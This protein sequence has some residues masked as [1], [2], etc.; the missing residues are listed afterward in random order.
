MATHSSWCTNSTIFSSQ[1]FPHISRTNGNGNFQIS[2]GEVCSHD[3]RTQNIRWALSHRVNILLSH[4]GEKKVNTTQ[5]RHFQKKTTFLAYYLRLVNGYACTCISPHQ[6]FKCT[7]SK[8][9][10]QRQR[11]AMRN[12]LLWPHHLRK[13]LMPNKRHLC[14]KLL[15]S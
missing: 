6:K 2:P 13:V 9:R 8:S 15:S 10:Q 7:E 11:K 3:W 5:Y 14:G 1:I 12:A 4:L